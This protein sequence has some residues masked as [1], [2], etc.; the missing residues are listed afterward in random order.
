MPSASL[1]HYASLSFVVGGL[2]RAAW[3]GIADLGLRISK[4]EMI[5]L[6]LELFEWLARWT[7]D[8]A[9]SSSEGKSS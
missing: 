4:S 2:E 8:T 9:G 5:A 3:R 7:T 1:G 6:R